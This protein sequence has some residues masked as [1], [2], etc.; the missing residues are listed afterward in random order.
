MDSDPGSDPFVTCQW[1]REHLHDSSLVIADCRYNLFDHGLGLREYNASHIPGAHFLNME[2]DL[3]GKVSEHGGRHPL[4]DPEKFRNSMKRIGLNGDSLLIAY[5]N[6]GSGAARLWW[7]LKFFGHENVK[8]LNGGFPLW[9]DLDFPVSR[10]IN[11]TA[12]GNI[13]LSTNE[14][15]LM[16]RDDLKQLAHGSKIVDSRARERYAG[17][18]EPID[19]K[20]GHIPGAVN[21]PYTEVIQKGALFKDRKEIGKLFAEVGEE[22]VLYC[23]SGVTSCVSFV[24]LTYIGKKPR[25]YAGSWSDWISYED[26]EIATGHSP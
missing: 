15:I 13:T 9:K 17:E 23:G 16:N 2:E 21:V 1:L 4:P 19:K 24:A 5:D 10:Q 3:A 11:G 22:P 18:V 12:K 25:L 8:I 14:R 7:L 26:N 6:D 20:A